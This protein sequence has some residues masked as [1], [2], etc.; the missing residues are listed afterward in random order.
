MVII[1]YLQENQIKD[2][3][4]LVLLTIE[5]KELWPLQSSKE[6]VV[7]AGLSQLQ[8]WQRASLSK[9]KDTRNQSICLKCIFWNAH[10]EVIVTQGIYGKL[11]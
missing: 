7:R 9:I 1:L 5:M 4:D 11:Q 8:L 3:E 10:Q 6:I 2:L